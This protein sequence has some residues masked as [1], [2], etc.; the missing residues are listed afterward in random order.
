MRWAG[1]V[2]RMGEERGVYRVLVGKSEGRRQL[3]RPTRGWGDHN[4]NLK[5]LTNRVAFCSLP[6]EQKVISEQRSQRKICA[7]I[8]RFDAFSKTFHS[9]YV[10]YVSIM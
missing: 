5:F 6:L 4:V 8:L 7:A 1:Y 3:R 2:A 10:K 9:L